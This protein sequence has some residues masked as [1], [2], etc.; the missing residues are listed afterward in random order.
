MSIVSE[1][2]LEDRFEQGKRSH[3]NEERFFTCLLRAR[4]YVHVPISDDSKNVRL[5]QFRHPDGFD[6]IPFFTSSQRALRASSKAVRTVSL[7]CATLFEQTRGATLMV[8]P[9]DGGAV[10]YP[11]EVA[12][13]LNVGT[14][15]TFDKVDLSAG[16]LN[17]RLAASPPDGLMRML[18]AS[19]PFPSY[20]WEIYLLEKISMEDETS[21]ST[22]LIYAGVEADQMERG[23]RHLISIVQAMGPRKP[24]NIEVAVFDTKPRPRFLEEIGATPFLAHAHPTA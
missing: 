10:L 15:E 8:N 13:L 1:R 18:V 2:E 21:E 3:L 12:I 11:E 22:L 23:A 6:A 7:P 19:A 20:I 14:L 9:N 17:I 4:V 5:I 24:R 16:L